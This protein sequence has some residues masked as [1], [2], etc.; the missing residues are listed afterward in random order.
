[1]DFP[2]HDPLESAA[3]S[4]ARCRLRSSSSAAA[5][6]D[7]SSP[8]P[9]LRLTER[10]AVA[11]RQVGQSQPSNDTPFKPTLDYFRLRR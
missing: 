1:M 3:E 4:C 10:P 6:L 8:I 2:N 5:P 11:L 7:Y 9:A